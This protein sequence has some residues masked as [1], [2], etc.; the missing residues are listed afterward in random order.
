MKKLPA[1]I[2]VTLLAITGLAGAAS[3]ERDWSQFITMP[4]EEQLSRPGDFRSPYI[5]Y[6]PDFG[7]DGFTA[8]AM[9]FRIDFDPAGTYICPACWTLNVSKLGEKYDL[10]WSDYGDV[11]SGYFGFQVLDS[12]EKV[13]IMSLWDALCLDQAGNVTVIKPRVL[14]PKNARI[15]E[16]TPETNGEGSFVQCI[17]P[18]EWETGKT[19]RF[20]LEQQTSEQDTE[21]FILSLTEPD[22]DYRAELFRFDSGMTGVWMD[23]I[24]GFVENF[25]PSAA[26][27]LRSLEFWNVRALT[28]SSGAWENAETV[29]FA[30]NN[31]VGIEDYEGSWNLGQDESACWIITSGVPGLCKSPEKLTGYPVPATESGKPN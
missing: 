4:T 26:G 25:V 8:C 19:Y 6:I 11:I 12:G 30:I 3:A 9:D 10:V 13:A 28:R 5:T 18:F 31:S 23:W 7:P 15:T 27:Q 16:H 20:V 22:G 2:L 24:G 17:I 29:N 1:L 21:L 14:S